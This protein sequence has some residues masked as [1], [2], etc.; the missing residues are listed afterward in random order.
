MGFPSKSLKILTGS[1]PL[2]TMPKFENREESCPNRDCA[3]HEDDAGS[4]EIREWLATQV[5]KREDDKIGLESVG[6]SS[7]TDICASYRGQTRHHKGSTDLILARKIYAQLECW[8]RIRSYPNR[9]VCYDIE[10]A[11][12]SIVENTDD[13]GQSSQSRMVSSTIKPRY[14]S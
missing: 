6:S 1:K 4:S 12:R 7:I 2:S 9:R 8:A 10:W 3:R 11:Q 5:L 14:T 13:N